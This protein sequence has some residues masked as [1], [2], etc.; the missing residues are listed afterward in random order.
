[1]SRPEFTR[2]RQPDPPNFGQAKRVSRLRL[3]LEVARKRPRARR[4]IAR[5]SDYCDFEPGLVSLV[6]LSCKRLPELRRLSESLLRFFADVET[7]PRVERILVDNGSGEELLD[8]ARGLGLYDRIVA[9]PAN[10][11]MVAALADAYPKC[12]GEF[13]LLVEDDF[14]LDYERPFLGRALEVL[15]EFPEIGIVRLKN[16]NNWWKPWRRIAPI[17]RTSSGVEFWT[18]LPSRD[19]TWNVWA[20]GSVLFRKVSF[21]STGPLPPEGDEHGAIVYEHQYGRRYNRRWLAAKIKGCYPFVQP[22]DA[23]ESPG[24]AELQAAKD[25]L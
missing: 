21:F 10:I 11:G 25:E 14:V 18:W 4:V 7:Y 12:R 17:R 23:G 19:R 8:Y 24:W 15:A 20:A 6:V 2:E 1:M 22:N 13:I 5:S 9:H 3:W 16:Q